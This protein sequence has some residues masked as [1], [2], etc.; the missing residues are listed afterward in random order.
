MTHLIKYETHKLIKETIPTARTVFESEN[1]QEVFKGGLFGKD[2]EDWAKEQAE[3]RAEEEAITE[4]EQELLT[5]E[6]ENWASMILHKHGLNNLD[7]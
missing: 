4:M 6:L 5:P 3:L 2:M 1:E 7:F